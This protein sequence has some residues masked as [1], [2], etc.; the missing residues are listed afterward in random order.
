MLFW[1]TTKKDAVDTALRL[2]R[3]RALARL[4]EIA[5][6]G[7]FDELLSEVQAVLFVT[8]ATEDNSA[9]REAA[10]RLRRLQALDRLGEM[11]AAGD[12]DELM[13]RQANGVNAWRS[14]ASACA[15]RRAPADRPP[16]ASS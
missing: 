13:D 3:A 2:R 10:R 4:T 14:R 9:Q 1:T 15:S 11:G 16:P 12:F 5:E 8:T 7:Q 6:T